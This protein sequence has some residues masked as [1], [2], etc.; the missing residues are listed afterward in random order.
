MMAM[1]LLELEKMILGVGLRTLNLP[2]FFI[3]VVIVAVPISP[4][5]N[6]NTRGI[7]L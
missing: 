2:I 5:V 3:I 7:I 4:E 1:R 6:T